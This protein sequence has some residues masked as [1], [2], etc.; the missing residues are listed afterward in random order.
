MRGSRRKATGFSPASVVFFAVEI[1]G[2]AGAIELPE[3]ITQTLAR[4]RQPGLILEE[5]CEAGATLE[6]DG[7]DVHDGRDGIR[8]RD[9]GLTLV[10]VLDHDT[11]G[12]DAEGIGDEGALLDE[13]HLALLGNRVEAQQVVVDRQDHRLDGAVGQFDVQPAGDGGLE[14]D[15]AELVRWDVVVEGG[16]SAP[17][18]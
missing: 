18:R 2:G 1:N 9:I 14:G 12:R 3:E 17:H 13:I 5:Q 16:G 10:P 15:T 11:Q 4:E 6:A 7:G 8:G